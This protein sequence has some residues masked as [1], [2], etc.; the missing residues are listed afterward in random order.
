MQEIIDI[1][2]EILIK[3][4]ELIIPSLFLLMP[5]YIV[6][7]S[8]ILKRYLKDSIY[9]ER[10]K[11]I[12]GFLIWCYYIVFSTYITEIYFKEFIY[13]IFYLNYL[14]AFLLVIHF[15]ATN[16]KKLL[17]ITRTILRKKYK[18]KIKVIK[19]LALLYVILY[20]IL[21]IFITL[22][23][24]IVFNYDAISIYLISARKILLPKKCIDLTW[25]SDVDGLLVFPILLAWF[26]F[27][28]IDIPIRIISILLFI[29]CIVVIYSLSQKIFNDDKISVFTAGIWVT[30]PIILWYMCKNSLYLDLPLILF[31]AIS[32]YLLLHIYSNKPT[33]I[34]SLLL[35][36]SISLL[37]VIKEFGIYFA[38]LFTILA[39]II[40]LRINLETFKNKI[41]II[42]LIFSPFIIQHFIFFYLFREIYLKFIYFITKTLFRL[43]ILSI[44]FIIIIFYKIE[45]KYFKYT[46]DIRNIIIFLVPFLLPL[47]FFV[48]NILIY[49]SPFSSFTIFEM[50]YFRK[51]GYTI[52][53][54]RSIGNFS[55][56]EILFSNAILTI[57][58]I[59]TIMLT[60]YIFIKRKI[61][62]KNTNI[63]YFFL[64]LI[65]FYYALYFFF[66]TTNGKIFPLVRRALPLTIPLSLLVTGTLSIFNHNRSTQWMIFSLYILF[67]DIIYY[68]WLIRYPNLWWKTILDNIIEREI[69]NHITTLISLVF[70][71]LVMMFIILIKCSRER[72]MLLRLE[73]KKV[74]IITTLFLV[75][76]NIMAIHIVNDLLFDKTYRWDLFYYENINSTNELNVNFP[77]KD[78]IEYFHQMRLERMTVLGFGISSLEFFISDISTI[79]LVN[80]RNWYI[81]RVLVLDN[82]DNNTIISFL[83]EKNIKY[84]LI[85]KK[86]HYSWIK[87]EALKEKSA[88]LKLLINSAEIHYG[89]T[90][91]RFKR[92]KSFKY[93]Y[94]WTLEEDR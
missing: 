81:Y 62:V 82:I 40:Y 17:K 75:V 18:L 46:K 70:W 34:Y 56:S 39:S 77:L 32:M 12:F 89:D 63:T 42:L 45:I 1:S 8:N 91:Y 68:Y 2:F 67:I 36:I 7:S 22:F 52:I 9:F 33:P 44:I 5:G 3:F 47:I 73:E 26:Y 30:M 6:L 78:V 83:K 38:W 29:M 79:D 15:V 61:N 94:L 88:F 4:V 13:L 87:Y 57:N 58:F 51:L 55:L 20:S 74:F 60:F 25:P 84:F 28:S 24:P 35:G 41:L 65:W 64:V 21:V 66:F 49:R 71:I 86:N 76:S 10:D 92:V 16:Y 85:P 54:T 48:N 59:P 53:Y 37:L 80:Y 69:I 19:T 23:V 14:I 50:Q 72:E 93:Y 90:V 31:S 43:S 11:F 27:I